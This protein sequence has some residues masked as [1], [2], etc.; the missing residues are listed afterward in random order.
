[1]F[2]IFLAIDGQ[3]L[4]Y[5]YQDSV[6]AA[7]IAG[8]RAAGFSE[9]QL[10]GPRA[11]PWTFAAKGFA[12]PGGRLF[13]KGLTISTSDPVLAEGLIRLEP[14]N[15]QHSSSNADRINLKHARKI[16]ISDPFWEGQETLAICFASPFVLSKPRTGRTSQKAYIE[17]LAGEDLSRAF[18]QGLTRRLGRPVEIA[19]EADK[20]SLATEGAR[21]RI[22]SLRQA[23]NRR[24]TV[25]AFS[26]HLRL[27]GTTDDLRAAYYAGLGE[28]TRYGFGCPA[29][30]N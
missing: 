16:A 6:H 19:V 10:V 26:L 23:P 30:L 25:P 11:L 20:L 7:I 5:S 4:P 24:V 18:S 8:L 27:K 3:A 1:M 14:G 29:T 13:L 21:P 12:R 9:E 17:R 28:K 22:V 15:I 2:R